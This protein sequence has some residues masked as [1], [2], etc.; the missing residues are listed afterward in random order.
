MG[1]FTY[2]ASNKVVLHVVTTPPKTIKLLNYEKVGTLVSSKYYG[3][4]GGWFNMSTGLSDHRTLS[5]A[6]QDGEPVGP[7]DTIKQDG[8][9]QDGST[10][11]IGRAVIAYNGGTINYYQRINV[12]SEIPNIDGIGRWAQGGVALNLGKIDWTADVYEANCAVESH[13]WTAMVADMR[14]SNRVIYL[15]VAKDPNNRKGLTPRIFRTAIEEM[16]NIVD[17]NVESATY[18]GILLDGSKSSQMRA[19]D[20]AGGVVTFDVF[21]AGGVVERRALCQI[22]TYT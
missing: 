11:C 3:I 1:Y 21:S 7:E 13:A 6:M 4:N 8:L 15:I 12:A 10:N 5:I 22:I 2:T 14:S 16:L 17:G 19:L 18:K 9:V 20:S